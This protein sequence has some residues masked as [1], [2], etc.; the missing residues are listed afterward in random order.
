MAAQLGYGAVARLGRMKDRHEQI[1]W[2][3]PLILSLMGVEL[4]LRGWDA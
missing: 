2:S 1:A 4:Q 3:L